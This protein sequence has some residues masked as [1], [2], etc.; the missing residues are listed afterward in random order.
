M[1]KDPIG[2]VNQC[3]QLL[4]TTPQHHSAERIRLAELALRT[5]ALHPEKFHGYTA[6]PPSAFG[7]AHRADAPAAKDHRT[8]SEIA[9]GLA[10]HLTKF[11][12][13]ME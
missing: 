3:L 10:A 11:Q 6:R 4:E 8:R 7:R 5:I 9:R 13:A 1:L 12:P 2:I